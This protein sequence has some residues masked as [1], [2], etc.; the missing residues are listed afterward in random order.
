MASPNLLQQ[1]R[2]LDSSSPEFHDK[3]CNILYGEKYKRCVGELRNDDLMS[4]V[5]YLDKVCYRIAPPAFA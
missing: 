4:L 1:F 2:L 3:L 5:D